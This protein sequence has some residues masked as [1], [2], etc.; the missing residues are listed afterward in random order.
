MYWQLIFNKGDIDIMNQ[1]EPNS[2]GLTNKRHLF[3]E[4]W[5]K[6]VYEKD[7][8]TIELHR[9]IYKLNEVNEVLGKQY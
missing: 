8:T 3:V 4:H 1:I 6:Y 7:G 2:N 9:K 5:D